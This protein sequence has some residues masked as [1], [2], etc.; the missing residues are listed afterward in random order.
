MSYMLY[1]SPDSANIVIRMAL[2]ELA[3]PYESVFVDRA[4]SAHRQAD[5][6]ALNP[7]G[8]L[9][10]LVTPEQ[11]EPLFETGAILLYLADRH[12]G[13]LPAGPQARGRCL[14]WLFFLS[15][16][17]HTELR[18]RFYTERYVDDPAALPSVRAGLAARIDGHF[19]LIE[20]E[21][22]RHGQGWLTGPGPTI[23]DVYLGPL[24]RW[25]QIY[26]KGDA[27]PTDD[28]TAR[29]HLR[30][31]LDSLAARP[32]TTRAFTR[33]GLSGHPFLAPLAGHS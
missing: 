23:C 13:L 9:P 8:L 10:V 14:K 26:P 20:H 33:E 4:A 22:A 24:V 2:E 31:L 1:Y 16:T 30:A 32:A 18:M 27:I 25:A 7:Q 28:I 15:N 19:D 5:Y 11:D 17:L 29:P 12:G 3:V 21:I 6:L